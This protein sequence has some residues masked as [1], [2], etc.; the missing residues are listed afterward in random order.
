MLYRWESGSQPEVCS[1]F[2]DVLNSEHIQHICSRDNFTIFV[3]RGGRVYKKVAGGKARPGKLDD[4][5]KKKIHFADCG[6]SHI[7]FLS[8]T[9]IVF[10]SEVQSKKSADRQRVISIA[11]PEPFRSLSERNIIQV[12]CGNEHSLAVSKDGQVF[13]WGC[14]TYGQLGLGKK[15]TFFQNA[16][17]VQTFSG[18]PVAQI[19]AGGEHSLALTVSGAVFAFGRNNHG[20]LGLKVTEDTFIPTHVQ[21]LA[22]KRTIFVSCGEEH[23]AVLTKDGF[24]YTFGAGAFGQLGHNS[25]KDEIKPRLVSGLFGKKVSQIACGSYHT[26]AFVPSSGTI[27]S[28]GCREMGRQGNIQT[29]EHSLPF[30]INL[31][32]TPGHGGSENGCSIKR[33][34]RRIFAGAS[35]SF[36]VCNEEEDLELSGD[37]PLLVSL[38]RV[39]TLDNLLEKELSKNTKRAIIRGYSSSQIIN[40]SFLDVSKDNHFKTSRMQSGLDM[41]SVNVNFEK[42]AIK[43]SVLSQVTYAI[44]AKLLDSL[45]HSPSCVE[46]LRLYLVLPELVAVLQTTKKSQLAESL[47][48]AITSLDKSCFEVLECWWRAMPVYYFWRLVKIYHEESERLLWSTMA[49]IPKDIS[50][51]QNTLK[52]LQVLYKVN[53]TRDNRIRER[54]FKIP[55]M[56]I[57][58]E[59]FKEYFKKCFP[60]ASQMQLD[61]FVNQVLN[62]YFIPPDRQH[63]LLREYYPALRKVVQQ[64][65]PYPCIFDMDTKLNFLKLESKILLRDAS[66][67]EVNVSRTAVLQD[68]IDWHRS[69]NGLEYFTALKVTFHNE[70]CFGHGVTQ[71]FFTLFSEE[72]QND[73]RIFRNK[74]ESNLLWFSNRETEMKDVFHLVGNLCGIALSD[75]FISNF[76]FPLALYKKL[77]HVQPTLED[78]KE[79]WPTVG[80]SLQDILDYEYDDFEEKH[81]IYFSAP[82][83]TEDGTHVEHELI[84]DGANVPVQKHNRKQFVD[85]FVDYKFNTAVEKQFRAFSEG[86]RGGFPLPIVDLFLPEELMAVIHGN[87]NYDWKL[88]EKNTIYQNYQPTDRVIR[89]FWEVFESLLEEEKKQFI[90]FLSGSERLPAG[91]IGRINIVIFKP[92][93]NEPDLS[94]PCAYTCIKTLELPNYSTKELLKE[95]LLHAIEQS[96]FCMRWQERDVVIPNGGNGLLT[97]KNRKKFVDSCLNYIFETSIK[98]PFDKL[99]KGFYHVLDEKLIKLFQPQEL[100]DMLIGSIEYDW[101]MLEENT[102]YQGT[103]HRSH[104]TIKIFWEV[105]HQMFPDQKKLFLSF[106]TG[107]RQILVMGLQYIK[108]IISS[109]ELTEND[110]PEAMNCFNIL[111][112][113]EYTSSESLRTKLVAAIN[114]F[115]RASDSRHFLASF[116]LKGESSGEQDVMLYRWESGSQPEVCSEFEDVLNSE[117][118][119]HICS[120][121]N[122]TIFVLRDGRVYKKVAGG[123]ARPGKLDGFKKKKIHF[124]DCG[125]SHILFLS[126]TGIVFHSEVQ[127]KK[128]ADRQRVISIA[129]PEPFRSLSERNI[130][131]VTCGNEHSL[132]VSKDGQVFAWGC[133]TYGQLGLGKKDTSFQNDMAVQTFSGIPVAQIAAGGEHSLALTVSGAVFAF[134]RNNHGQLGLKV[135][136]DTFIPTH[137]QLL[138]CKRTIFVSC[139]EEHTAVLTKDGFVYTFGAGAFGQLGHNSTKD[140]IKP[141]LVSGL[142]GKKVSQIACGSYHTLAFVPSSG[143][144]YS[145]G[146][147]EMGRQGNIQTYEHSLPFPINLLDTPGHGGSENGCSIKRGVR[148]IFAGASQ[149]FAVCNEEEDL[150]LSGDQPLLVSLKRVV[151]LDNLLEKELSKNTK[152]AIIRGYSSSQIINASFLD[153]SKDNHFKTSRMQSGLDMSSVNVNFEKMAIK[154][155]VLSQVTYAIMA[156]LLDSLPHSPS[157][158]EALRLYLV[159]PELV[160]V[161]QTTKKS[162]LAESLTRAI[163]SLDKSCFEVLECWWR[164]MPVYYFWRL[165][166]IYHEESERLLW[167]TMAKIPKD[168][169]NLQNTLKIL[170]VLYKVNSTRDNRIR[171]RNFKIPVMKI[172][173]ESFKEYFKKCFP[174][175]SQMQLDQFVNQ[176]LNGYFI[177]PDRQHKLLRE[178][179]P[180]LRKV[181]QQLIPYPCIFDM[182]TK[183]NFL[184]LESKILLRDAS[185]TEV[186][187]SRTAVLQDLIDWHR[188]HNGL[189]YFTALK[190]TFGNEPCF[191][192]GVTQEFFTLF[193]EELQNDERIFRNEEESNLLWFSNRE[194]EMKDVFHLVGNLCGIALSDNFVSNFHFPLALYKKLLHVQPTLEDLKELWPTV[195]ASLQDILDYEYDDFEEKHWIY[196]SAPK[197]TEDGTHVEHE[198]IADGANVPVQ[199]HNRKQF[200][201]AFVDY[202]FNTAVEKQFRAFSEGFRGGF[203][204][205]IVDLFL[206]EELMAV[207]H[208]NT[209]Y[210]WKLLEKNTIYDDYQPTDRVIRYFWEVFESLL[211]EEKKQFIFFLSGSERLPAGGIGRINIVIFKPWI[212]QPDLSYPRAYTCTKSL[213]LPNYST[214][215]LL[216]E[217]LL[218]AIE[219]SEF[220]AEPP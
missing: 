98:K 80:A 220:C 190:V 148:R 106:V 213:E 133:N 158:V 216:K 60:H 65:I 40:A 162:Q 5:K 16:M 199:K 173:I 107:Y 154:D 172:F 92:W 2:E 210:N 51:L 54:N 66:R 151:T 116:H 13:A 171:E 170:Q 120:R 82:K 119:Q 208:G 83:E 70:P 205:P 37:Q 176:V 215:E 59:S 141:R 152:R 121:D 143:T 62:G 26:L 47:T 129:K 163:T 93:I 135:T 166:K 114:T 27:Y 81:W 25:T 118:I 134:G 102:S 17:A 71:E 74:E 168:I 180:A 182:D 150:E 175:A 84:A 191:G 24:V 96:E 155:S 179:Y 4:F 164:A 137:V 157:C 57:F 48:R 130:I 97:T 46:A 55:V 103:Y 156:K 75:N 50:N 192:H 132:A 18:I 44:M 109:C 198:L 149:S 52:I 58:I 9:G 146:C 209:N 90:F 195:G 186:N 105:F 197:E 161:L 73:E 139:G 185:R 127:S 20:Q 169:S 140:E 100:K 115:R 78:L 28:F 110:Y 219:Q 126:E 188:S 189:E 41:S 31:L 95:R 117:H 30:P 61:Q 22:C 174:H 201:D 165:V 34:V 68:L 3:L 39:V 181:V 10:H 212:N 67:T 184:K 160:A 86:F 136:E 88:L 142:F 167:S 125:T 94:Y 194:T 112:L 45:P 38:K 23:T 56:K 131:Q 35:Q 1:E 211:E 207:I 124:A 69:H 64:L 206:P 6:T 122:F 144:I 202:K 19:A 178:Y 7:L 145:F 183:L 113:P 77:L 79:L 153:V 217:R 123:K 76:H 200:V 196:F 104:P 53:S 33:G 15:D 108:I 21:L 14:N 11:K 204:L 111:R 29:Y 159:L 8:E 128:S 147:R 72:L 85:A 32:D 91:G 63:K 12:T 177:P 101:Q 214:K 36:A 89:Y 203:P 218:H 87:T 99:R 138:A 49:K 43:D 42:M 187:V 193:S